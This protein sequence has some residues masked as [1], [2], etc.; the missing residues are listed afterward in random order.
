MYGRGCISRRV[1]V[2]LLNL[3]PHREVD[4]SKDTGSMAD[5]VKCRLLE[6]KLQLALSP[7]HLQ[8][9]KGG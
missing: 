3:Y 5:K 7:L 6:Y 1:Y 9:N 8:S 4:C 2:P